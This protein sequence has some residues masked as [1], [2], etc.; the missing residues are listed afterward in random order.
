LN[1][2][3]TSRDKIQDLKQIFNDVAQAELNRGP[4]ERLP[5]EKTLM[6]AM[7]E[8]VFDARNLRCLADLY[9]ATVDMIEARRDH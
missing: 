9:V 7:I 6:D 8:H 3:Q 4:R 5:R 1:K 2:I